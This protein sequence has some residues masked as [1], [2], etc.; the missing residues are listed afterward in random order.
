MKR[1]MFVSLLLIAL[2]VVNDLEA[3]GLGRMGA[4]RG[5]GGFGHPGGRFLGFGTRGHF[6]SGHGIQGFYH[7]GFWSGPVFHSP[8]FRHPGFGFGYYAP[9][10]TYRDYFSSVDYGISPL[11]PPIYYDNNHFPLYPSGPYTAQPNLKTNCKDTW[12]DKRRNASLDSAVRLAFQRQC[13]LESRA[14]DPTQRK[15]LEGGGILIDPIMF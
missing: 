8:R 1:M 14:N 15:D 9:F 4:T 3:K 2:P 5:F 11:S 7:P 12:A 6:A 10:Y 13:E